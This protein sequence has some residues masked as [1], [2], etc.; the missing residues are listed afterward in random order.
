MKGD[1]TESQYNYI[2]CKE[3]NRGIRYKLSTS[4]IPKPN[5]SKRFPKPFTNT[6]GGDLVP[7]FLWFVLMS[8]ETAVL[9]SLVA[10]AALDATITDTRVQIC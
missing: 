4:S 5:W 9:D 10:R 8:D 3:T 6:Y 2:L 1:F 7:E